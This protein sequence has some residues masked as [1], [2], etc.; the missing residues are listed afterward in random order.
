MQLFRAVI[1]ED[2]AR[3]N[4]VAA[5]DLESHAIILWR[6]IRV[7]LNTV[8]PLISAPGA[9]YVL[10]LWGAALIRGRS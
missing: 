2:T 6:V 1:K 3:Q 7:K 10:K 4:N 8:F 9:Y 5:C